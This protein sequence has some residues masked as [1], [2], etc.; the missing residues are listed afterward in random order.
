[1]VEKCLCARYP[2]R[3]AR[4]LSEVRAQ[5]AWHL[6]LEP[7]RTPCHKVTGHIKKRFGTEMKANEESKT[8]R[9]ERDL[10]LGATER[11]KTR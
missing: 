8:C 10:G 3:R 2:E 9:R 7:N 1:M 4:D 11:I 5:G 6:V